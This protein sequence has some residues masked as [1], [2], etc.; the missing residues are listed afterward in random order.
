MIK[1][2][3]K[4]IQDLERARK[5][6]KPTVGPKP[7]TRTRDD[8]IRNTWIEIQDPPLSVQQFINE[9]SGYDNDSFELIDLGMYQNY[10]KFNF[11]FFS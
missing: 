7:N 11:N 5:N 1:I 4:S 2:K 10:L 9:L 8:I 6:I 3:E